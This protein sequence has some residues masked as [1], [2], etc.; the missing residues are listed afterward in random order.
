MFAPT[1][2][3]QHVKS[4]DTYTIVGRCTVEKTGVEC[5]AYRGADGRMW[6]RP[7]M[8]MDDGR[9]ILLSRAGKTRP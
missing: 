7:E 4:G 2:I 8:E 3:I 1:D 6:I 9:F 5:Y